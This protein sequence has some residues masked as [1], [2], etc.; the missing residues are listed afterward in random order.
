MAHRVSKTDQLMTVAKI[1]IG[2]VQVSV[3]HQERLAYI[4]GVQQLHVVAGR[5]SKPRSSQC[6]C[7]QMLNMATLLSSVEDTSESNWLTTYENVVFMSP[8]NIAIFL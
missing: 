8:M 7:R 3:V 4:A 1:L 5:A 2:F 6:F